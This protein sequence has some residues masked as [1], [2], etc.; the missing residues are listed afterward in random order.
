MGRRRPGARTCWRRCCQHRGRWRPYAAAALHGSTPA[1]ACPRCRRPRWRCRPVGGAGPREQGPRTGRRPPGRRHPGDRRGPHPARLG[2]VGLLCRL[3]EAVDSAPAGAL[4]DW[5]RLADVVS[6][7]LAWAPGRGPCG[8]CSTGTGASSPRGAA[9]SAGSPGCWWGAGLSPPVLQH[10]VTHEGRRYRIDLAYP[11]RQV[12]LEYDGGHHMSAVALT[13]P[14]RTALKYRVDG[15]AL[16]RLAHRAGTGPHRAR[17]APGAAL[18]SVADPVAPRPDP[19]PQPGQQHRLD[20][21]LAATWRRVAPRARRTPI[22]AR[23][24]STEMT[25]TLAMPTPPT[26]RATAPRP[27][28]RAVRARRRGLG[29]EGIGG[30]GHV[31]LARRLGVGGRPSTLRARSTGRGRCAPARSTGTR[32]CRTAPRRRRSRSAPTGRCRAP[33]APGRGCRPPGTTGRPR[34]PAAG[35]RAT[36]CPGARR[37]P[38]PDDRGVGAGGGVDQRPWRR[39]AR[40]STEVGSVA[41]TAM[42]PL[43]VAGIRSVAPHG[44]VVDDGGRRPTRP[45]RCAGSSPASS[46]AATSSPNRSWPGWT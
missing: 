24:S 42:P 45:A 35:R 32:R 4:T 39:A 20:Q 46:A 40:V 31:D 25:I 44:D 16:H 11:E 8:R 6:P 3:V 34:T 27:S 12:G 5:D 22:S 10:P 28:S 30:P 37:P 9:T 21:E 36:R 23:R 33:A 29:L 41:P 18:E 19:P 13:T 14:A 17:G 43:S 15:A 2:A 1:R 7:T 26:S 38:T